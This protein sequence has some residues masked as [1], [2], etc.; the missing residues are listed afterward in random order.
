MC[1]Q[2]LEMG[3]EKLP[4]LMFK[5]LIQDTVPFA[6]MRSFVAAAGLCEATLRP[7]AAKCLAEANRCSSTGV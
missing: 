6:F 5:A 4:V 1:G 3:S 2:R 7:R